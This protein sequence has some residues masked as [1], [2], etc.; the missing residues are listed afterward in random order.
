MPCRTTAS[1]TRTPIP[2]PRYL[3]SASKLRRSKFSTCSVAV[4]NVDDPG[5][6]KVKVVGSGDDAMR[7]MKKIKDGQKLLLD[8]DQ[9][10]LEKTVII[11]A[12]NILI[13]GKKP[14]TKIICPPEGD[15]FFV[16]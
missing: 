8:V 3:L 2:E 4:P 10:E 16:R 7:V 11:T 15:A 9:I 12:S 1:S 5:S 6:E 14:V 13:S